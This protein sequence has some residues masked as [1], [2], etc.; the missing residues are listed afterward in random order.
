MKNIFRNFIL[1]LLIISVVGIFVDVYYVAKYKNYYKT[2][3]VITFIG[4]PDGA[5]FGDFVDSEGNVNTKAY[6]YTD[7]RFT[8]FFSVKKVNN[9][10]IEKYIGK[11]TKILFNT[12]SKD[13]ASY[14]NLI[15]HIV[16]NIVVFSISGIAFFKI[17]KNKNSV[18]I[19]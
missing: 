2:D 16:I 10:T 8:E 6:L 17:R 4:L 15:K 11:K 9:D 1:F 13:I 19:M 18:N 7:F 14:D 3:A 12:T 5:V